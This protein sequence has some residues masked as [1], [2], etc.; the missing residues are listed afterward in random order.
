MMSSVGLFFRALPVAIRFS[1]DETLR[2]V[3]SSVREQVENGIR[4]SLYPYVDIHN[5]VAENE[6]A[7]ILYQGDLR[8]G[9]ID[10]FDVEPVELRW[11][12]PAVQIILDLDI[13]D[14][15]NGLAALPHFAAALYEESSM[16]RFR[17]LFVTASQVLSGYNT[18]ADVT[19][20]EIKAKIKDI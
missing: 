1:D 2:N 9:T 8:D 7:Y 18:Q 16:I 15:A 13:L 4:N 6:P 19:I 17:D 14:G 11:N 20:G 12:E 5:Q 10:G 3:F